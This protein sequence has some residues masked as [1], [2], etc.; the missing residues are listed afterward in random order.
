MKY[1]ISRPASADIEHIC[2]HIAKNNPDAA[3]QLEDRIHEAIK[4]SQSFPAS[5][6]FARM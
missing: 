2:D 6:T 1:R 3:D 4:H 5:G